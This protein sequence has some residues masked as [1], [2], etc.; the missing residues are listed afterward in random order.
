VVA[1]A[2]LAVAR[3]FSRPAAASSR[4]RPALQPAQVQHG[5][6]IEAFSAR[7]RDKVD[8]DALSAEMLAV[9]DQTMEPTAASLS[10]Q[11]SAKQR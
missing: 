1:G 8:L 5:P 11:H 3:Y 9:V 2:T 4:G 10:L 6:D 7:L